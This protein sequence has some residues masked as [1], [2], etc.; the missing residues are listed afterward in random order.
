MLQHR[1]FGSRI[2]RRVIAARTG[3]ICSVAD[4]RAG[5][6]FRSMRYQIMAERGEYFPNALLAAIRARRILAPKEVISIFCAGGVLM[7]NQLAVMVQNGND[8]LRP[9]GVLCAADRAGKIRLI[10]CFAAGGCFRFYLHKRMSMRSFVR[11]GTGSIASDT[12]HNL[13]SV[14]RAGRRDCFTRFP[15][16]AFGR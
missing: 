12:L 2:I 7:L 6:F 5:G 4:F 13:V 14:F 1:R 3:L 10:P 11:F 8:H 16:M 15:I 9:L